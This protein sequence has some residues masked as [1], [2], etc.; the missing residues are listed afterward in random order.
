MSINCMRSLIEKAV[1]KSPER[2]ALIERDRSLTYKELYTKINQVAHYLSEL[3]LPKGSRIGIYSYKNI[4]QVISIL[5]ILST[6][7]IF[8]PISRL[9]NQNR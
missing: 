7:Y 3:E 1:R 2:V 4:E 6:D 9:L 8:V 5:A